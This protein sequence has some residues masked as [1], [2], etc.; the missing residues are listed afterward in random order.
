VSHC[1][2]VNT[3]SGANARKWAG[4][5]RP[6]LLKNLSSSTAA[7]VEAAGKIASLTDEKTKYYSSKLEMRRLEHEQR[8]RVMKLKE[9][10]LTQK[11]Q[12]LEE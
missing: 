12:M 10:L 1:L 11:L 7:H 9:Q 5:R 8:M 4:R 3:S 6:L 2:K